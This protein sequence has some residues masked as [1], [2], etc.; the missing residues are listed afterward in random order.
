MKAPHILQGKIRWLSSVSNNKKQKKVTQVRKQM[1]KDINT[2][3]RELT[4]NEHDNIPF[5]F[6]NMMLLPYI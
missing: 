3:K 4:K 5:L 2:F 6:L 1:Q